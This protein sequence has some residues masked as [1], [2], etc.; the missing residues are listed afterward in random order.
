MFAVLLALT[1]VDA[2]WFVY[3]DIALRVSDT[4][5]RRGAVVDGP[6]PVPAWGVATLRA[7]RWPEPVEGRPRDAPG[8][9]AALYSAFR[10]WTVSSS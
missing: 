8:S 7:E 5:E 10:K 3:H 6:V 9:R 4:S 2:S 1:T